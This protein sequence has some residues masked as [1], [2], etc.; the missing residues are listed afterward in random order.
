MM[1][2]MLRALLVRWLVLAVAVWVTCAVVSGIEV[3]GGIATYLIV[4]AVLATV[5]AVLGTI[6]R[7][8]SFPLIALTLGLF[9]LVISAWMLL[10]TDWLM[11]SFDVDGFGPAFV[12]AIVIAIVT[13]VLD[14]VVVP[15]RRVAT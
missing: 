12:G 1:L 8:L 15:R 4:S 5:N 14:L 9:S 11:D 7:L 2:G 13:L 10:V 6:L 3:D